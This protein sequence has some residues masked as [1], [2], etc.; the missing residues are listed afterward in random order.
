MNPI[1]KARLL[2]ILVAGV[3]FA[4]GVAAGMALTARRPPPPGVTAIATDEIPQELERLSLTDDQRRALGPI[5][6]RG[7]GRVIGVIDQ[8]TPL[9]QSV[10]DST[11]AEIRVVLDARQRTT[12]DSVRHANPRL[13]RVTRRK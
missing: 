1:V 2:G 10:M 7:R 6:K 8:F 9:M 3:T 11:D 4:A 13:R 12:F 5:L